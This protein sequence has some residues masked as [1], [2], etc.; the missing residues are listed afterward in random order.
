MNDTLAGL[1]ATWVRAAQDRASPVLLLHG[2]GLGRWIWPRFQ[3]LLA[4]EGLS[5]V[6]VDLPGHGAQS[7]QDPALDEVI[8][9]AADAVRALGHPAVVGHSMGG[10]VAQV[11][12]ARTP[13]RALVLVSAFPTSGVPFIPTW[14]QVRMSW[15]YAPSAL[16]G[17]SMHMR[18]RDYLRSGLDAL[19]EEARAQA[20]ARLTP[21]SGRLTRELALRPHGVNGADIAAPVLVT[22]GRRDEVVRWQVGRALGKRLD[23][24]IWR[25][26]DLG[27]YPMLEPAGERHDRQVAEWLAAPRGASGPRADAVSG[28]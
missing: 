9:A 7:G 16:L 1:A 24:V 26:D 23:A 28:S 13:V 27:H 4:V 15:R 25:Y 14:A 11:V 5:S 18:E 10:Y 21:W 17:R 3:A 22:I 8:G 6:A 2:M 19:P 20:L 12:A